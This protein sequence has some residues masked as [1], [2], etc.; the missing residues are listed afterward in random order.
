MELFPIQHRVQAQ[1]N[2]N[3][4]QA[5]TVDV[6]VAQEQQG[7]ICESNTNTNVQD[8]CLGTEQNVCHFEIRPAEMLE[9][10]LMYTGKSKN[11]W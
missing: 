4:W 11:Y 5:V 3:K 9:T 10:V 8:I 1:R 6:C 7:F 2:G